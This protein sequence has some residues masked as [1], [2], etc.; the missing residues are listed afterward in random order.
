M[1]STSSCIASEVSLA[2]DMHLVVE[3]ISKCVQSD[4]PHYEAIKNQVLEWSAIIQDLAPHHPMAVVDIAEDLTRHLAQYLVEDT[5]SIYQYTIEPIVQ[6]PVKAYFNEKVVKPLRDAL[7][8]RQKH[9]IYL[10]RVREREMFEQKYLPFLVDERMMTKEQQRVH[11]HLQQQRQQQRMQQQQQQGMYQQ[12][13]FSSET[14]E[15]L[16]EEQKVFATAVMLVF[17]PFAVCA[18]LP[19]FPKTT[20]DADSEDTTTEEEPRERSAEEEEAARRASFQ[21]SARRTADIWREAY[22]NVR[23]QEEENFRREQEAHQA[24]APQAQR[25]QAAQAQP[26]R[27]AA[28]TTKARESAARLDLTF[29]F[30]KKEL[31]RAFRQ[32]AKSYHPDTFTDGTFGMTTAQATEHCKLLVSD[33]AFLEEYC[34]PEQ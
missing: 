34:T 21:R 6:F 17:F 31:G 5:K 4:M 25:E 9:Q 27:N 18:L 32:K 15:P 7:I 10:Q 22:E 24:R 1:K 30:T 20:F 3:G 29:P 11:H 28:P 13:H 2:A 33:R 26:V 16:T 14:T 23:R 19:P 12:Q 8:E